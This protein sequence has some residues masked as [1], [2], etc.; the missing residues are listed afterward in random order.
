MPSTCGFMGAGTEDAGLVPMVPVGGWQ[1]S[2]NSP[3][4]ESRT[5]TSASIG[6]P[7]LSGGRHE[8]PYRPVPW[9]AT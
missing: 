1:D 5:S 3:V 6:S 2:N 9:P 8:N 7:P 4:P